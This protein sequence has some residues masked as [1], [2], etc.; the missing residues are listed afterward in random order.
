MQQ[1]FGSYCFIGFV[2]YAKCPV[3]KIKNSSSKGVKKKIVY[4]LK[5]PNHFSTDAVV[6]LPKNM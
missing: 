5:I 6:I 3:K 4:L 2:S 1:S